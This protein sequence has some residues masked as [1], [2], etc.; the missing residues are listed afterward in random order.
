M[1]KFHIID[2]PFTDAPVIESWN[3]SHLYK[4]IDYTENFS[5]S[6]LKFIPGFPPFMRVHGQWYAINN[7]PITG[8]DVDFLVMLTSNSDGIVAQVRN[9]AYA[10][11]SYEYL[12]L[13]SSRRRFRCNA[14]G[15]VTPGG[16]TSITFV[17]RNNAER[18][19][20]LEEVGL[21]DVVNGKERPSHIVA[22]M[23]HPQGIVLWTGP[24]GSGK[25]SSLASSLGFLLITH[26]ELS[27]ETYEDPIEYDL[28]T[29]GGFGPIAQMSI[30][31]HLQGDFTRI[32]H[33]AARRSSDI[34]VVGEA[35]DQ[36][37]FR[38]LVQLA[39]MGMLTISTLHSSSVANTFSRILNTFPSDERP[40]IQTSLINGI[41]FVVQQRLLRTVEGKRVAIREYLVFTEEIRYKMSNMNIAEIVAYLHI[42]TK[43]KGRLLVDDAL[44]KYKLGIIPRS[45]Y[46]YI[47]NENDEKEKM[48]KT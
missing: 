48:M 1:N 7:T 14:T 28:R 5:M 17:M 33:N 31:D 30:S 2:T 40:Q 15:C 34:V 19:P 24:T 42:Q 3:E 47:K 12:R 39:D 41:Q 11:F 20:S 9:G 46:E 25:T 26:P 38:G 8:R 45:E 27:V 18:I 4:L 32:P 44:E 36:A 10:D 6:D 22:N 13:D 21:I 29:A 23:F 16:S 37:S 43:E 35:R